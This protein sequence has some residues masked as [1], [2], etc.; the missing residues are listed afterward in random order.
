[1]EN[2]RILA[3]LQDIYQNRVENAVREPLAPECSLSS[4]RIDSLAFSWMIADMEEKF[5]ITIYGADIPGLKTVEDV[6]MFV[7]RSL[8]A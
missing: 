1:M 4:L 8:E 7:K 5:N 3:V 2:E 6:I